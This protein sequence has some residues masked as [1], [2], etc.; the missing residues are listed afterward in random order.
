MNEVEWVLQSML[1]L[2]G[3]EMSSTSSGR[4]ALLTEIGDPFCL[5]AGRG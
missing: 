2:G 1:Y 5:G 4:I 3:M